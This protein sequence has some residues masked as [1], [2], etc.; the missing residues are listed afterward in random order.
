M[1]RITN[2]Q[3]SFILEHINDRPRVRIARMAG[4]ATSTVYELV[5]KHGGVIDHSL[6][7]PNVRVIEIVKAEYP[8]RSAQEIAS[9]YGISKATVSC[10][11]RKLK[12][13]HTP[14]TE[15]RIKEKVDKALR[16]A[17]SP[18]SIAAGLKKR[19][20]KRRMET[21]RVISG[22]PQKTNIR[23]RVI[24]ART[25]KAIWRLCRRLGYLKTARNSVTLAYDNETRRTR[26]ETLYTERYGIQFIPFR[27]K[28][29][30]HQNK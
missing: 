28:I 14:E 23:I 21:F 4:V 17:P 19:A 11:A 3:R 7:T 20:R 27:Q 24:P 5:R 25:Q 13:T 29:L 9:K 6:N 18:E 10:W 26:N 12:I 15:R 22:M 8:Y 2:E 30:K 1:P 16:E